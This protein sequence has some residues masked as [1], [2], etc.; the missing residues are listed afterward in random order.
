MKKKILLMIA[1][2]SITSN[3]QALSY[4]KAENNLCTETENYKKWKLLSPTERQNTI[5]PVKCEEF[6]T[7]NKDL[8]ASVGNTFNVDYK[9]LRKFSLLD[10]GKVSK[11]HDQEKTNMCWTFATTSTIESSLLIEQNKEVARMG[12]HAAK[13]AREDIEKNLGEA[14]ITKQNR[15]DYEYDDKEMITQK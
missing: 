5:M 15:L 12:G 13:V 6:Y 3:V 11:A 2:L 8:S 1:L 14:V 7:T 10:Y 9:T 4:I